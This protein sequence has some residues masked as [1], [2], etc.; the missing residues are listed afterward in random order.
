M[1]VDISVTDALEL[2]D[3]SATDIGVD[4]IIAT[5]DVART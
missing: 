1:G 2:R 3:V 5:F 4:G